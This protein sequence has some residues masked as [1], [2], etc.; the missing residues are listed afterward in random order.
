LRG[1]RLVDVGQGQRRRSRDRA[2]RGEHCRNRLTATL[3]TVRGLLALPLIFAALAA[4]AITPMACRA[5]VASPLARVNYRGRTIASPLGMAI[6]LAA[7]VVLGPLAL[8][9]RLAG[10]TLLLGDVGWIAT[11]VIGVA[12]LGLADDVLGDDVRGWRGN[13][14]T[15]R[16]G[17]PGTGTLKVVGT[18]GLALFVMLARAGDTGRF[19]LGAAVLALATNAFNLVD[20]RPGRAVKA[21][22]LL[23]AA[24]TVAS[25]QLHPLWSLGLFAG[26]VLVVGF[27]DLRERGMLGDMGANLVGALAGVWMVLTLSA[28]GL[29]VALL[30]LVAFTVFG[31]FRS[32]SAVIDRAP[33]LRHLDSMGRLP[34][35]IDT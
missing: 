33:V 28:T 9:Q 22:V 18:L 30:L 24:L 35:A 34:D 27:Y 26:P 4:L 11:F 6:V 14:A 32:I 17:R 21:L 5:L 1:D 13:L 23:G 16:G 31:E 3:A 15:L 25:G 29:L 7:L 12:L 19:L 10:R 2:E 20:L 8:A